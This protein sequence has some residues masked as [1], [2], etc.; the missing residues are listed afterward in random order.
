MRDASSLQAGDIVLTMEQFERLRFQSDMKAK[1][2]EAFWHGFGSLAF[3]E[4][5]ML[6]NY[7]FSTH[8][9]V[10]CRHNLKRCWMAGGLVPRRCSKQVGRLP[11]NEHRFTATC[12]TH[13]SL[14]SIFEVF[15]NLVHDMADGMSTYLPHC[16]WVCSWYKTHAALIQTQTA[17]SASNLFFF[18]PFAGILLAWLSKGHFLG[19]GDGLC[20]M[21]IYIYICVL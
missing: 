10:I 3:A 14:G 6:S 16:S 7:L 19:R 12:R 13:L 18:S 8:S 17:S 9:R 15:E 4:F 21:H 5:W 20:Y 2:E 11:P 1:V